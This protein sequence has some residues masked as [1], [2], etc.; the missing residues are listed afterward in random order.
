MSRKVDKRHYERTKPRQFDARLGDVWVP[1]S[2]DA[3]LREICRSR[4]L[5]RADVVR[6]AVT[7]EVAR[8]E[9]AGAQTDAQLTR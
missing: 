3:R 9:S 6:A 5:G 4:Q 1:A 2:L 8:L 7:S